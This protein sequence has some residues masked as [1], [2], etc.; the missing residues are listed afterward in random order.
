MSPAKSP[1]PAS[2]HTGPPPAEMAALTFDESLGQPLAEAIGEAERLVR[3][4][5]HISSEQDLVEGYDYL[6]GL[7]KNSIQ[8]A[9]ADDSYFPYFV[10]PVGPYAKLGLDNPDALYFNSLLRDDAEYVISGIRGSTADLNFQ[11]MD[12]GYSSSSVPSSLLAFD[13]RELRVGP[14]G[15]YQL[16]LSPTREDTGADCFHL[17]ESSAMLIVRENYSDW[18]TERRGTISIQRRDRAGL[19]PSPPS[20]EH[21]ARRYQRAARLLLGQLRM[22]FEFPEKF[23]LYLP[24]NTLTEPRPTPGG[25]ATQYSSVGHYD[26]R[27]DQAMIVTVPASDAPYQGLQLG[28]MWYLS[29]DYSNH[30]TSLTSD[31]ARV[32]PDG[33]IRFVVAE[34]DPGVANWLETTG[35]RQ[36]YIQLRWQRL[37]RQLTADD[38]P[39]VEIVD[40][41]E[42]PERLPY[43][44]HATITPEQYRAAIAARQVAVAARMLG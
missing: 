37:S 27:D 23:Y 18:S 40:A 9:W 6:Q 38:G 1:N 8:T 32:D 31:Q 26:L 11:I 35:H 43:Y 14:D 20:Q 19:A 5:P 36:G 33:N 12:G 17:P 44:D 4:A 25:L 22:F 15:Q 21:T 24:V 41:A 34:R 13:D 3:S 39:S 30:Q 29:M 2:R 7:I 10:Q 42:L 28:N 16:R